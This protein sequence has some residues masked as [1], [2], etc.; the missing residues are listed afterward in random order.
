MV[1]ALIEHVNYVPH[2]AIINDIVINCLPG[3]M[4]GRPIW[5]RWGKRLIKERHF[6]TKNQY[7]ETIYVC[8]HIMLMIYRFCIKTSFVA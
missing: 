6:E 3:P 7:G 1:F 8:Y 5:L 4:Q 2:A